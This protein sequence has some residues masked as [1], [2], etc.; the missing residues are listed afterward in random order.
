MRLPTPQDAPLNDKASAAELDA[1]AVAL[2]AGPVLV[3]PVVAPG[4][5]VVA[6]AVDVPAPEA[7]AV[8]RVVELP[9]TGGLPDTL[10]LDTRPDEYA[11]PDGY[12]GL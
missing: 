2:A 8:E 3:A 11:D 9:Y 10:E 12:T 6:V 1:E 4:T 5:S 7:V